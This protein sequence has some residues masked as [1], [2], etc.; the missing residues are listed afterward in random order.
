MSSDPIEKVE[1]SG[2]SDPAAESTLSLGASIDDV[3]EASMKRLLQHGPVTE[4][5]APEGRPAAAE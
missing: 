4:P 5:A 3:I 1:S 2:H